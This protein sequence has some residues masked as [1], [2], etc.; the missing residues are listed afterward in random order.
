MRK[1]LLI[2]VLALAVVPAASARNPHDQTE[3]SPSVPAIVSPPTRAA[4][5]AVSGGLTTAI[6]TNGAASPA[7]SSCGACITQCWGAT[8]R[9]GPGD[10]TG[11]VYI[12]QHI[13]WCGNG[14][15]VTSASVSQTYEQ[16]GWYQL[17]AEFGPWWSGGCA[18]CASLSASGYIL[19]NWT[20]QLTGISH[21]GTTN[22]TT[23]VYAYGGVSAS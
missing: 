14:A 10:W 2:L 1:V 19:W 8:A 20:M 22:L 21:S 23:T 16:A 13:N 9:S 12:Y 5:S 17:Q 18:G 4:P 15:Q 3:P 6:A 7:S 11:H